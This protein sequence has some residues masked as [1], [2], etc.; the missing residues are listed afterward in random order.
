MRDPRGLVITFHSKKMTSFD[1]LLKLLVRFCQFW[2][3]L[4]KYF[5]F[6]RRI[7][8]HFDQLTLDQLRQTIRKELK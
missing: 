4:L 3:T 5:S 6:P 2:V 1:L 7:K 8:S